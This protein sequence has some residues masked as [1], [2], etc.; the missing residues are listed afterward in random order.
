MGKPL[1]SCKLWQYC[2]PLHTPPAHLLH[3]LHLPES[4]LLQSLPL[5]TLLHMSGIPSLSPISKPNSAQDLPP[6]SSISFSSHP[7]EL[8]HLFQCLSIPSAGVYYYLVAFKL[9]V[10]TRLW[11][12]HGSN[13]DSGLKLLELQFWLGHQIRM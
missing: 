9:L 2:R 10:L 8:A 6:P 12:E 11:R 1:T 3:L 13:E 5:N 7:E 4:V